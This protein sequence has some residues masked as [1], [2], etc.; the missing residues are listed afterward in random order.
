MRIYVVE[1]VIRRKGSIGRFYEFPEAPLS[2]DGQA[3]LHF[4][5]SDGAHAARSFVYRHRVQQ[6]IR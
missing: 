4:V 2:R 5:L 1:I 3:M 6:A